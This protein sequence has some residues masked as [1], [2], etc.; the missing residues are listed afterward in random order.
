M[1]AQAKPKVLPAFNAVL[2]ERYWTLENEFLSAFSRA[3]QDLDM[4]RNRLLLSAVMF[5]GLLD[6]SIWPA[7][8][9]AVMLPLRQLAKEES[10]G[11]K[12]LSASQTRSVRIGPAGRRW[13]ADPLTQ[14]LLARPVH[15]IA[16]SRPSN[17]GHAQVTDYERL[18]RSGEELFLDEVAEWVLPAA[19]IKSSLNWPS[20]VVE[21][22]TGTLETTGLVAGRWNA[23][24][25][26]EHTANHGQS[27]SDLE[28][29]RTVRPD[30]TTKGRYFWFRDKGFHFIRAAIVKAIDSSANCENPTLRAEKVNLSSCLENSRKFTSEGDLGW[31]I[32]EWFLA[33][34]A[35]TPPSEGKRPVPRRGRTLLE[36]AFALGSSVSWEDL[37]Q[38]PWETLH[39]ELVVEKL[40]AALRVRPQGFG[41]ARRL[42]SFLGFG[43]LL[44][45]DWLREV[46]KNAGI[47]S[48]ILTKAEFDALLPRLLDSSRRRGAHWLAAMLM[49]RCGLR[50]REIV[51][52]EIDHITVIGDIVEL[53]VAATPYV[54]LKNKTSARTLPLHALLSADELGELLRWR[55]L[56]IRDCR[57]KRKHARLLF[58]TI[59]HPD[60]YDYLL[61]PIEHAIRKVAGQ[62]PAS[63]EERKTPS[64]IFARC[65]ILRHSFVSYAV[66]TMMYPR[67]DGGFQ[68]PPG[69]T[70]DLVSLA[71]RERLE[72]AL[73]SEG[74][75]GL[76]SLEAVR[77]MTGHARYTR[78]IGTYTHVMDLVAGAYAW[79][80]SFEPALPATALSQLTERKIGQKQR[81]P[82]PA[83]AM[84]LTD[85]M[86]IRR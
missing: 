75:L 58:A 23:L 6:A 25:R 84:Q 21:H 35:A 2:M 11:E 24:E 16:G 30:P 17:P 57:G 41:A 67:D 70:P 34:C 72:R 80:R 26:E 63:P 7:W 50:P 32:H 45:P 15:H 81:A 10:S 29:I 69:I 61:E 5:G 33:Y 71:R 65:S 42:F 39:P 44:R 49:F 13:F 4:R 48:E 54:A 62:K 27:G 55:A 1:T 40:H 76:S 43:E 19:K 38:E 22:C 3:E 56:R 53:K 78:T 20:L 77:Q 14:N 8:L 59:Y 79:R 82:G 47:K 85:Q 18:L 64:Y 68:M 60:D 51:A 36:H 37:W 86:P 52:L 83:Q 12:R 74:H 28:H 66:A 73:L 9:A 46:R 31:R